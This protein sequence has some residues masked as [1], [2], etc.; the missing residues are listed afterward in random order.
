MGLIRP[1]VLL[2]STA[3]SAPAIYRLLIGELDSTAALTRYL[4]AVPIAVVMLAGL[5]LVTSGYGD[6]ER[7]PLRLTEP[8]PDGSTDADGDNPALAT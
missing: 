2:L 1:S 5:R 3:M 7:Q 6:K 8:Q 4:I